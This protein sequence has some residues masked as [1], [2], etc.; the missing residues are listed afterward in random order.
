MLFSFSTMYW[1][2]MFFYTCAHLP[3]QLRYLP[4]QFDR[5]C[6]LL[7]SSSLAL[8]LQSRPLSELHVSDGSGVCLKKR[9]GLSEGHLTNIYISYFN[10]NFAQKYILHMQ[11]RFIDEYAIN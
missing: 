2:C 5:A 10:H 1:Y 7:T 6:L 4:H 11:I 9:A 3:K 8:H